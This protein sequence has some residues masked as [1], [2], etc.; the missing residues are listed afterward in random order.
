MKKYI[1]ELLEK[2]DTLYVIY[3]RYAW[4][5]KDTKIN[6]I[7]GDNT[8]SI[9][10]NDS[11]KLEEEFILTFPYEESI[12]YHYLSLELLA[13]VL[14]NVY[15]HKDNNILFNNAHKPYVKMFVNDED[16]LSIMQ[17]I[18]YNQDKEFIHKNM[19]YLLTARAFL[20]KY[21]NKVYDKEFL[22][23]LDLRINLVKKVLSR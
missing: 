19:N 2:L 7:I 16:I 17:P 12:L 11:N 8:I 22:N 21:Q 3:E 6:V 1:I 14:G 9:F 5:H 4:N 20:F 10:L 15:V 23:T 13:I 18:I